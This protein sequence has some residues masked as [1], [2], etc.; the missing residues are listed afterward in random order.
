MKLTA[1]IPA[2]G[3]SKGVPRKNIRNLAGRPLISYSIAACKRSSLIDRV[4]VSTDDEEIAKIAKEC[5]AEVPF[6]RPPEFSADKSTD[7]QVVNHFY[8]EQ[9]EQ[10]L[11]FIRPTTPLR[12]PALLDSFIEKYFS[13]KDSITG[14]RSVHELSESPYKFFKIVDGYFTGFFDDFNGVKDYTNLPRQVFPKAYHPNGY[15]DILKKETVL[16]GSD[17]GFKILPAITD[18]VIEVDDEYHFDLLESQIQM[19]KDCIFSELKN[20]KN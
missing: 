16:Q 20:G 4:V 17:F 7:L 9:G 2:R 15:I 14:M 5:G 13:S 6:I 10:D 8:S 18:Y 11:A 19:G 3:G 1:L 12:D